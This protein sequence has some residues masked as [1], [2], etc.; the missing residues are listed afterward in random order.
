MIPPIRVRKT[1]L[2]RHFDVAGPDVIRAHW[3]LHFC[4]Q[5]QEQSPLERDKTASQLLMTRATRF[6]FLVG[7]YFVAALP[8]LK[9]FA[10][11]D[12]GTVW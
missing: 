10:G 8:T 3:S 2:H 4:W 12:Y 11:C 9:E 6:Q 1:N 5:C 7:C